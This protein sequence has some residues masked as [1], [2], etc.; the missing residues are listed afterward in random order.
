MRYI[1]LSALLLTGCFDQVT[2]TEKLGE[3][4]ISE[5]T[6]SCHHASYC[7]TCMPG[8]NGGMN[9]GLKFSSFC[10]GNQRAIVETQEVRYYY[11]SGKVR[12]S[13][14]VNVVKELES[15]H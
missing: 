11:E 12:V 10:S 14:T 2:K 13:D 15:C 6:V 4:R 7:Y 5:Q 9:C 8:F 1:L 3:P